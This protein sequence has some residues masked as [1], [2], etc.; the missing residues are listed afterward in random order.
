MEHDDDDAAADALPK[1]RGIVFDVD[2]TLCGLPCSHD[3][4]TL[5]RLFCFRV[6][7]A[8]RRITCLPR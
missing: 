7:K 3:H 1:L 5:T 2:G 8:C 4:A 6:V